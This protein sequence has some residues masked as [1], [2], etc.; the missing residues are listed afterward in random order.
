ML[1]DQKNRFL[2]AMLNFLWSDQ[3][4]VKHWETEVYQNETVIHVLTVWWSDA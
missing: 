1:P 3:D 2:T 4:V